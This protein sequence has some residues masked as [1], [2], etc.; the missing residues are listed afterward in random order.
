[1]V[2]IQIQVIALLLV[3]LICGFETKRFCLELWLIYLWL[4]RV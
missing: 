2:A 4:V 1:M 3:Y